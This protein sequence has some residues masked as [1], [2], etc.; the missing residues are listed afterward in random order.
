MS[1]QPTH[2]QQTIGAD[3]VSSTSEYTHVRNTE[4]SEQSSTKVAASVGGPSV[5]TVEDVF[6][7]GYDSYWGPEDREEGAMGYIPTVRASMLETK[8]AP[9][10]LMSRR[11]DIGNYRRSLGSGH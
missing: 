3:H 8:I 4:W 2:E 6:A 1:S 10:R 9:T 11:L 5:V 7:M